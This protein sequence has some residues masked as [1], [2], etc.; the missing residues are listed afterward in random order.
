[1][2][3]QAPSSGMSGMG[4]NCS[5]IRDISRNNESH[6]ALRPHLLAYVFGTSASLGFVSVQQQALP[7]HTRPAYAGGGLRVTVW[8]GDALE[9]G[10]FEFGA[11][12]YINNINS[13][14]QP[15]LHE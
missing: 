6:N 5:S 10:L 13:N 1:M 8:T 3:S 4:S 15:W 9:S 2:S 14:G 12:R 7:S 11:D